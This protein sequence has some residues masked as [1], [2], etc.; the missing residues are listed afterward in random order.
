[1]AVTT[2]Q[3][4]GMFGLFFSESKVTD[5]AGATACDTAAFGRFFHAMLSEGI[6]LAPSAFEAGF[7]SNAHSNADI[8]AT[9]EAARKSF[10][11]ITD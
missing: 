8:D 2:N 10:G 3:V 1:M 5:F 9:V 4:P 6:Y 11:A 7:M